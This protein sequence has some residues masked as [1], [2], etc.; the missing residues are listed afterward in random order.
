MSF[1]VSFLHLKNK[2]NESFDSH[3]EARQKAV[4]LSAADNLNPYV[5]W[6]NGKIIELVAAGYLLK[7][8]SEINSLA[9]ESSF[10]VGYL[11]NQHVQKRSFASISEALSEA[12]ALSSN[13]HGKT[14]A[15]WENDDLCGLVAEGIQFETFFE[16]YYHFDF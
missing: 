5:V 6:E 15:I 7:P 3:Q 9:V 10:I 12:K 16:Q 8:V 2:A 4:E 13:D 1:V 11:Y 14:Y